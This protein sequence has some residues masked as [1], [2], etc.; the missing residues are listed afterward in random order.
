[1]PLK[2]IGPMHPI[3][4]TFHLYLSLSTYFLIELLSINKVSLL[5]N[6]DNMEVHALLVRASENTTSQLSGPSAEFATLQ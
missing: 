6:M 4:T 1:M 2:K 5:S 3:T